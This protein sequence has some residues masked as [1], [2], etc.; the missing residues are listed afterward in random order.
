MCPERPAPGH[1]QGED[2]DLPHHVP[3]VRGLCDV[4]LQTGGAAGSVPGNHA[5]TGGQHRGKL[6]AVHE[7]RILPAVCQLSG[8]EAQ[9]S[10]PQ[11]GPLLPFSCPLPSQQV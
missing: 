3:G 1:G 10:W 7:L 5:G 9:G 8:R 2:A 11:V 4:H 6:C